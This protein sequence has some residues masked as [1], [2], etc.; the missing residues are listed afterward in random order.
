ME[1]ARDAFIVLCETCLRISDYRKIQINIRTINK[2]RF[3]DIRQTK[4][5]TQVIIPLTARFEA[6]WQKYGNKLPM[7]PEQYVNKYIKTIA[8]WC[9]IN[10]ELRWEGSKYG[11]KHPKS[12]KKYEIITCHTGRRTACTNMY[13]AGIPLKDIR[14]ISG[15]SSDKQLLD[16]IKVDKLTTAIRLSEH[17]YFSNLKAV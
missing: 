10:E 16:Y 7:I 17:P 15:H 2:R 14:E 4:T 3:I 13:L 11:L 1:L 6:I 5:G 9:E 12:A 8:S